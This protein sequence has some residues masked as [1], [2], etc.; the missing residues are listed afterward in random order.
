MAKKEMNALR[1]K[2]YKA[3]KDKIIYLELKPGEKIFENMLA[4]S[5]NVSRTPVREALLMLEHEKLVTCNNSLGF[6]VK[7]FSTKDIEEYFAL[8]NIIEDFVIP[9]V[10]EK[11]TEEEIA[12]LKANVDEGEQLIREGADIR[13][14]IR[15]ESEFHELLYLAAKSDILYD[16]ISGLVDKFQWFRAFA[17]SV[18][19][20]AGSSLSHHKKIIDFI[21][22]KNIKGFKRIMRIHLN[23][24]RRRIIGL[25]GLLL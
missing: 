9:L 23:E 22:E 16:T 8:R 24:A 15:S 12:G 18:P 19:E 11:I 4:Q 6:I 1:F 14:I 3:I 20:A 25:P 5:L 21:E 13:A 7:R 17:L 2:A 10:V